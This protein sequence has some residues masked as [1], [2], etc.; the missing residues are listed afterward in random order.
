MKKRSVLSLL[1]CLALSASL[2][3]LPAH[4]ASA[5]GE[6]IV[7]MAKSYIGRVPYVWGGNTIDGDNPGADCTGFICAIFEKFGFDLWANRTTLQNCGYFVGTDLDDARPGDILWYSGH[8]AIYAG[9]EDGEHMIVH[10]TGGY[11][12]DVIC[13][14]AGTVTNGFIGIIHINGVSHGGEEHD[15]HL[16]APTGDSASSADQVTFALT[17]DPKFAARVTFSD[18]NAY[19]VNRIT[20][21]AGTSVTHL[22]LYLSDANGNLIIRHIQPEETVGDSLTAFHCWWDINEEIGITLE[23]ATTYQYAFFGIFDGEE[24]VGP[25]FTFTTTGS[26][27][28]VTH[29]VT[30]HPNGGS[31]PGEDTFEVTSDT[32][33]G[34]IA[35]I[36]RREG[37]RFAGWYT[38]KSG[39]SALSDTSFVTEDLEAYAHWEKEPVSL[40]FPDVPEDSYYAESVAWAVER[41][42]A[43][44]TGSGTFA[45]DQ[46][47]TRGQVVTFLYRA[48]GSPGLSSGSN[49]FSDV[50]DSDYFHDA[51]LWALEEGITGGTS[52]TTFS[53]DAPC[54][55]SQAV[56]FLYKGLGS[57]AVDHTSRFTDVP[58]SSYYASAVSWAVDRGIT[59][60]TGSTTFSPEDSCTRSQVVTFLYRALH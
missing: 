5:E 17:T 48:M 12:T 22:G 47:C 24:V 31:L 29:T 58:S 23:P 14:R 27:N 15:S 2:L 9:K 6:D 1:L 59:S 18:T 52:A 49:P 26:P 7:S 19:L 46:I 44:G 13:A 21:P 39:G 36:P 33:L 32:V 50:K 56:T 28:P 11:H 55:R 43:G 53:P 45:P 3:V 57:P 51:V 30:F 20:K 37:Y 40:S 38:R 35:P 41:G 8:A 60:G 10:E 34:T 4:A 42:I 54:T 16:S 25:T